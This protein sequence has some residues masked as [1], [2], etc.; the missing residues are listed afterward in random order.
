[1]CRSKLSVREQRETDSR[2]SDASD[3][4]NYIEEIL[5]IEQDQQDTSECFNLL[6]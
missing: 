6:V 2:N 5:N 4:I 1:M 3:E